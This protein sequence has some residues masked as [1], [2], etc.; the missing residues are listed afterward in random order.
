M[1]LFISVLAC[2]SVG[3][4][5]AYQS[6]YAAILTACIVGRV[7]VSIH[8]WWCTMYV[9]AFTHALTFTTFVLACLLCGVRLF[10]VLLTVF[11]VRLLFSINL[12]SSW[13]YLTVSGDRIQRQI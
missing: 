11:L 2:I 9:H 10:R 4:S 5:L 13:N 12:I 8:L 6:P 3:V 7:V 1:L